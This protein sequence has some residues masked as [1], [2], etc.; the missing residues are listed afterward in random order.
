M[1][2]TMHGAM[3]GPGMVHH[4]RGRMCAAESLRYGAVNMAPWN[5]AEAAGAQKAGQPGFAMKEPSK[6]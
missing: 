1:S 5:G 3:Q 6:V 4:T 2:P